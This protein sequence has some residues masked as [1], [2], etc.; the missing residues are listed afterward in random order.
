MKKR[1]AVLTI[2]AGLLVAAPAAAIVVP[3]IDVGPEH[4][5]WLAQLVQ[6]IA[7]HQNL[8][9]MV[10]IAIDNATPTG[11]AW[12]R[13]T[14]NPTTSEPVLDSAVQTLNVTLATLRTE[15]GVV[16]SPDAALSM[17]ESAMQ[18]LPQEQADLADAEAAS[19][20][21]IGDLSAQQAGHRISVLQMT[22]AAQTRQ[23]LYAE[24]VQ[25]SAD[26]AAAMV[27]MATPSVLA[28]QM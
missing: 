3:V 9:Q 15:T 5:T 24:K 10:Q 18:R 4:Q 16:Q 14:G 26:E 6:E 23:F 2:A 28:G 21:A 20:G 1:F 19:D 7:T 8:N 22:N 12:P 11:A 27:W 25:R 17:A 13:S